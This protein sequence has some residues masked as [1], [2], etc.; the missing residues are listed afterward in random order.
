[1][2][3]QNLDSHYFL[4]MKSTPDN[5]VESKIACRVLFKFGKPTSAGLNLLTGVP[6]NPIFSNSHLTMEP[7]KTKK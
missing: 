4:T 5:T 2:V 3:Y 6:F 1:M 7:S